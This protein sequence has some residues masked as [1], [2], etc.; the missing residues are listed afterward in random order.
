MTSQA[1]KTIG[2]LDLQKFELQNAT[3]QNLADF[4]TNPKEGLIFNH[5]VLHTMYKYD[6]TEWGPLELSLKGTFSASTQ[7][8]KKDVVKYN[9]GSYVALHNTAPVGTLPTNASFWDV[10][11]AAG[12]DAAYTNATAMPVAVGGLAAG[13]VFTAEPLSQVLNELLYPYQTPGFSS[14]GMTGQSSQIEVG[15]TVSGS[16]TFTWTASNPTNVQAGSVQILQGATVLASGLNATGS[17]TVT[18]NS[19]TNNAPGSQTWTI[20]GTNTLG[21]NFQTTFT[22]SWFFFKFYGISANTTLTGSQIQ[23]LATSSLATSGSGAGTYNFS[24]GN[25]KYVA[26]PS[27]FASLVTVKDASN[28]LPEAMADSSSDVSYSN[29]ANGLSYA[30]VTVTNA[31]GVSQAYKI[32]RTYNQLGATASLLIT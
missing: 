21:A 20:K 15:T 4:P 9:G 10:L 24:A 25:F 31:L 5:S 2:P 7:Y 19:V 23:A 29:V 6:G 11:A 18:I 1:Q 27:T 13:H 12:T 28:N 22:V 17:T 32:Y 16:K 3:I 14:F 30:L 26:I 8:Y